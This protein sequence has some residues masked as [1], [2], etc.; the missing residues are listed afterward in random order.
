MRF[1]YVTLGVLGGLIGL[2]FTYFSLALAMLMGGAAKASLQQVILA[3][4]VAL[5]VAS[6]FSFVA[7]VMNPRKPAARWLLGLSGAVWI[8]CGL[9][10]GGLTLTQAADS[11]GV[12]AALQLAGLMAL[13]SLLPLAALAVANWKFSPGA[14]AA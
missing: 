14:T 1:L 8:I 7:G 11:T 2:A 3:V 4:L 6:L 13:P 12:L 5:V 9:L 10:L